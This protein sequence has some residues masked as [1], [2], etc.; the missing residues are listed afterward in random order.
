MLRFVKPNGAKYPRIETRKLS[1][2]APNE[3]NPRKVTPEALARLRKS[4]DELGNLSPVTFNVRTSQ[5]IGGHQR[6]KC[7]AAM[8]LKE[9]EA[10][11][12]DLSPEKETSAL[13]ALNNHAGEWDAE[14]LDDILKDLEK[15]GG[16]DAIDLSGFA[17]DQI[18]MPDAPDSVEKNLQDL[19]TI[20]SR[21]KGT[22]EKIDKTDT[23][24]YLTIIFK[25][26]REREIVLSRL[27]LPA[28]ER[29]LSGDSV[30]LLPKGAQARPSGMKAANRNRSGAT[31]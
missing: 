3:K 16:E 15:E 4:L 8:G 10:W 7:L 25:S 11:C 9:T 26:R 5:V 27:N 22:Q 1:E 28:D 20:A 29:Y 24:I 30:A 14:A 17:L 6:L 31:G 12:V 19:K 23:E 13:L 18:E 21:K 2:L